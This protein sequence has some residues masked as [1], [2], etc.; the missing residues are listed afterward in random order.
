M[1][2]RAHGKSKK[3]FNTFFYLSFNITKVMESFA[4][5]NKSDEKFPIDCIL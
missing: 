5:F 4:N 3:K 2:I 1:L